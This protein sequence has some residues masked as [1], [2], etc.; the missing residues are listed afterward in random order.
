M[1]DVSR[2]VVAVLLVLV[3][4]VSALGTWAMLN[5]ER[6]FSAPPS[7]ESSQVGLA[8]TRQSSTSEVGLEITPN[9]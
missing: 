2:N 7:R 5:D 1:V 8:V 6:S 3:I 4:V 9:S